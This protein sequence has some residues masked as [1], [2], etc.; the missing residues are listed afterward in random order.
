MDAT[1]WLDS[2]QRRLADVRARAGR[3]QAAL[4][5]VAATATSR[6][7]AVTVTVSP[8]GALQR[9]VLNDPA[10]GL[11]RAQ[12]AAASPCARRA[13]ASTAAARAAQTV[14]PLIGDDSAAMR[15]LRAQ[16]PE[17]ER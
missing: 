15:F 4:A 9:L 16:L 8:A 12:L 17:G 5:E 2:Y 10:D 13:V 7:G 14:A 3:A 6:D 1:T 11:S